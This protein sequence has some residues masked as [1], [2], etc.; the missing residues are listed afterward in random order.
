MLRPLAVV[1]GGYDNN[2]RL[3]EVITADKFAY[4]LLGIIDRK[5]AG[6]IDQTGLRR[7]ITKDPLQM[8]TA[9]RMLLELRGV[10][11]AAA[12][13]DDQELIIYLMDRGWLHAGTLAH[14]DG[15]GPLTRGLAYALAVDTLADIGVL[16]APDAIPQQ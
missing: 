6:K 11:A 1:S 9:L 13:G 7:M 10:S 3:D 5:A 8:P 4:L 15:S 14:W 16:A 2:W 12:P